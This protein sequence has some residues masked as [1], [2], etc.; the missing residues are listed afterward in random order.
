[1]KFSLGVTPK[2]LLKSEGGHPGTK[3]KQ[4]KQ[5]ETENS[6]AELQVN[7]ELVSD[8][9]E[10][11]IKAGDAIVCRTVA[12][13]AKRIGCDDET[14]ESLWKAAGITQPE[15]TIVCKAST[16][17]FM[18]HEFLMKYAPEFMLMSVLSAYSI[19]VAT[20]M[21]RLDSMEAR[22]IA[23]KKKNESAA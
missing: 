21:K 9:V 5:A 2:T 11:L 14:V 8:T 16:T 4:T 18:R 1:M 12:T 10:S 17:I 22:F 6:Q 20:V 13:K 3:N 15:A 19:R 7:C 23:E